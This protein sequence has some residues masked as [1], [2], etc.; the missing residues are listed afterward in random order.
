M[1]RGWYR[2]TALGVTAFA[3]SFGAHVVAVNLPGYGREVGAGIT[4]IGLLIAVYDLA[5][6]VAKPAFGYVADRKGMKRSLLIAIGVFALASISYL[7]VAPRWLIVVRLAQ[8]LGAAGL[9]IISAT[10]VAEY[11]PDRRGRAFGIYNAIKGAGYVI[12]PVAGGAIVWAWDLR[13]I[14]VACFVIGVVAFLMELPLPE[15][16]RPVARREDDDLTL[17]GFAGAFRDRQMV[18]W[19]AVTVANMFLVGVLFGFLPVYASELGYDNLRAGWIVGLSA[20]AFLLVQ[21][22]AGYM[23]DRGR[24]G[25]IILGGLFVAGAAIA[26]L[27]YT[28]GLALFATVLAGGAGTGVVWTNTDAMVSSIA[29]A[30]RRAT[31]LGAA[32]SFKEL[33]DMLGPV[34]IGV[35]AHFAGLRTGFA[36]CGVAGMAAAGAVAALVLKRK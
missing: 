32:G 8:G 19:Y 11:F 12:G 25:T 9:S 34:M 5:E 7:V 2:L 17:R 27:P 18:P 36:V 15:P 28:T 10:L 24:T 33:G 21:P 3:T 16:E 4:L 22:L 1:A 23:A 6:I 31:A 20:A 13:M 26:V 14:F 30:G 29:P 35:L